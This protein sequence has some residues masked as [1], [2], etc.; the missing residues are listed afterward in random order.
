MKN[1][2]LLSGLLL[3]MHGGDTSTLTVAKE[4]TFTQ[5][6]DSSLLVNVTINAVL[7]DGSHA[8]LFCSVDSHTACAEVQNLPPERLPP[9]DLACR[10][11]TD[12]MKELGY[13]HSCTYVDVGEFRFARKGDEITVYHRNGKTKFRV[14]G[15]W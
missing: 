14:T 10:D 9:K 6:T 12:H 4:E 3:G 1:L 13:V 15:S 2:I 5:L 11:S 8:V 7:P